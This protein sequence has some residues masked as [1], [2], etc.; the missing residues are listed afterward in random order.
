MNSTIERI[1]HLS[2]ADVMTPRVICVPGNSTMAEAADL[3][4]EYRISGAPV[5]D[6]QGKCIGV[7]SGTDFI[8]SKAE[9]L[10]CSDR[11]KHLLTTHDPSGLFYIEHVQHDLVRQH[12]SPA[13]QTIDHSATLLRAAKCMSQEHLHRLIVLDEHSVPVGILTSIDLVTTL[14][15]ALEE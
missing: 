2:V 4:C 1:S 5:I 7:L 9:E 3:L 10:D 11:V 14:V 13:V 12:M 8:H 6:E 15:K